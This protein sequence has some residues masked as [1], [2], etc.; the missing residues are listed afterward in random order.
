MS[1]DPS[2]GSIFYTTNNTDPRLPG[3]HVSK[4]ALEYKSPI[5]VTPGL[6]VRAR[7]RSDFG[8]WSAPS[9]YP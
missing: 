7:V 4:D 1:C 9:I 2:A 8:L 3:G 5:P 6:Q